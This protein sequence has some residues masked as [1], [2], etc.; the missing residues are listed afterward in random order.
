MF[1]VSV[2]GHDGTS[3]PIKVLMHSVLV[4]YANVSEIIANLKKML[5]KLE[6]HVVNGYSQQKSFSVMDGSFDIIDNSGSAS[7]EEES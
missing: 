1:Y 3:E 4:S 5:K 7:E 2:I 6:D